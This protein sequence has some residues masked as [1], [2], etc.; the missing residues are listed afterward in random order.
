MRQRDY[1]LLII[2]VTCCLFLSAISASLG[3]HFKIT[4][5]YSVILNV[6][7]VK[8]VNF[9]GN[10]RDKVFTSFISQEKDLSQCKGR[11]ILAIPCK[12]IYIYIY[13]YI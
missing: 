11:F 10:F 7:K 9:A 8:F 12:Y 6:I 13:I 5:N 3:L 2:H 4:T 1:A